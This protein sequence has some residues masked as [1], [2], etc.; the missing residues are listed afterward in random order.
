MEFIEC[1]GDTTPTGDHSRIGGNYQHGEKSKYIFQ[2][3]AETLSFEELKKRWKD[4][5]E[6]GKRRYCVPP[7]ERGKN[8]ILS[9]SAKKIGDPKEYQGKNSFISLLR[10]LGIPENRHGQSAAFERFMKLDDIKEVTLQYKEINPSNSEKPVERKKEMRDSF[11]DVVNSLS[12][13][14]NVIVEGVAGSGK[15]HL[16]S[17]LR[18]VISS[19]IGGYKVVNSEDEGFA[20]IPEDKFLYGKNGSRI[21]VVVF[22]PSTSYEE[23]VSGIRPNFMKK[24]G[25]SEFIS[26]EGV[27][28]DMCNK[29]AANPD[30]NYLLFID[31]INRANTARVFG[32]LML[33][34]E[35]SKRVEASRIKQGNEE[36]EIFDNSQFNKLY[37]RWCALF[38]KDAKLPENVNAVRLQTPIYKSFKTDADKNYTTLATGQE[39]L[40]DGIQ[41]VEFNKLVVP[42]NL[43]VLGTMNTT[44][45]SV[46]TI[47]LALRRRFHWITQHPMNDTGDIHDA[48]FEEQ[49]KQKAK[50][51][52]YE[53]ETDV[54]AVESWFVKSN[55]ELMNSVGPDARLGHAY[56]FGKE[57]KAEDI[58][59][60]LIAQL[61]EIIFTFNIKDD[62]LK[63]IGLPE[64][65]TY[66]GKELGFIGEGL[67]RRPAVKE[68]VTTVLSNSGNDSSPSTGDKKQSN[69]D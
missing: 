42:S 55:V 57:G 12:K 60:A 25:E 68:V 4:K 22:H 46:G 35:Q 31:E 14:K 6:N 28:V 41:T 45:R 29:A 16:L 37:N 61:L 48:L 8:K 58:A 54:S 18:N 47:D 53:L 27:F 1:V 43:H 34:L 49:G 62:V 67:G 30:H 66:N 7:A 65:S 9:I 11:N 38:E 3:P 50:N 5:D 36:A 26:Q 19:D 69:E 56:F 40:T 13:F 44:D 52:D 39:K 10:E 33:V 63:E 24:D 32:D 15:S 2:Y 59:E 17:S 20:A 51:N 64:L 23:F 21:E